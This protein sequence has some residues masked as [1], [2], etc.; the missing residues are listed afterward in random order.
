MLSSPLEPPVY[1]VTEFSYDDY[2]DVPDAAVC[3]PT[4]LH[5]A[6][7]VTS[8]HPTLVPAFGS[9]LSEV[10]EL[11][12]GN[13][14]LMDWTGSVP[15][16][17]SYT[18]PISA[19]KRKRLVLD[20]VLVPP[21]SALDIGRKDTTSSRDYSSPHKKARHAA[22]QSIVTSRR[23][24][25]RN[26]AIQK[27]SQQP[28][29]KDFREAATSPPPESP[30]ERDT[31][32]A[33]MESCLNSILNQLAEDT[34]RRESMQQMYASGSFGVVSEPADDRLLFTMPENHQEHP[35]LDSYDDISGDELSQTL[36]EN[37][38][39][40]LSLESVKPEASIPVPEPHATGDEELNRLFH[41]AVA[42]DRL[43]SSFSS[44]SI[45]GKHARRAPTV[46]TPTPPEVGISPDLLL[47]AQDSSFQEENAGSV[48]RI[49]PTA[50]TSLAQAQ[51]NP[52]FY[53]NGS[54]SSLREAASFSDEPSTSMVMDDEAHASQDAGTSEG[55]W[56]HVHEP[57]AGEPDDDESQSDPGSTVE[58][59]RSRCPC[60]QCSPMAPKHPDYRPSRHSQ[61]EVHRLFSLSPFA[62][63]TS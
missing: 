12:S 28:D 44:S 31:F 24:P 18:S 62:R 3:D 59:V 55:I 29:R 5:Q 11:H 34:Q 47:R 16:Q 23:N 33:D 15:N 57:E 40:S 21:V 51:P 52:L 58:P 1:D 30:S 13:N 43:S 27:N 32:V 26:S 9:P 41:D 2:Q 35:F 25:R 17:G 60:N 20:Y 6:P 48:S 14:T 39:R 54:V 50:M 8:V 38:F 7:R 37:P 53:D 63:P 56:T 4:P 19:L 36:L 42:E 46:P 10:S 22:T 61:Q 45:Q 49:E